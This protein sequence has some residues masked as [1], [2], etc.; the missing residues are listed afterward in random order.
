M[1]AVLEAK[2]SRKF[3]CVSKNN[4]NKFYNMTDQGDGTFIAEWGRVGSSSSQSQYN[5]KE[6]DKKCKEKIKKGYKD[7]TH[8]FADEVIKEEFLD[9]TNPQV[10]ALV[11]SLQNYAKKSVFDN[12]I[13][14]SESVTQTMIDDA[15][16]LINL[17][18]D[19]INKKR[20]RYKEIDNLLLE[21]FTIIPRK[22]LNVNNHL[23]ASM[24][25]PKN[26]LKKVI[27]NEQATLDVMSGEVQTHAKTKEA[28][29]SK[30]L[31]DAMGMIITKVSDEDESLIK[32]LMGKDKNYFLSAYEVNHINHRN[33]FDDNLKS[34]KN[35]NT[36]LLWHGSRNE[37]WWS[38]LESGLVL[39]PS[40]AVINGKMFGYGIYFAD[41]A[42][43]SLGYSSLSGSYWAGGN[44]SKA[45]LAL[46]EVH[47]GRSLKVKEHDSWM[48][49]LNDEVLKEKGNYN[50]LFAKGGADLINNE[51]IVY[52]EPQ[53][54]IKYLVEVS[55]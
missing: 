10:A 20:I 41:K 25:D 51:Y 28:D 30:T 39:R 4:N 15:Q 24:K 47:L 45:Y 48:Y 8:I 5:I 7:I 23:S 38:I 42:Q 34:S 43:K 53:C 21:L 49:Q 9:I 33:R 35:K 14:G 6:W 50:S 31:L 11:Q 22:M 29:K 13:I 1:T 27:A 46:Y 26:D 16:S 19:K 55:A 44:S 18:S 36:K 37:N 17:L 52:N 3:I 12:Y 32:K 40:N 2:K 54:T